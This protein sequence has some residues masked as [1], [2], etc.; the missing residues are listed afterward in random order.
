MRTPRRHG[1]VKR[2]SGI[3]WPLAV[4]F[5]LPAAAAIFAVYLVPFIGT[6]RLSFTEWPGI[7]DPK[8][9]GLANYRDLLTD[10]SFYGSVRI[11]ILFAVVVTIGVMVLATVTA[12]AVRQGRLAGMLRVIWFLP[13]IA[14]GTAIAVFW[15]FAFQ[16]ISGAVN[17]LL[18]LVGLGSSHA[19]LAS[20]SQARWAVMA[21][22]IWAGVA[23]P[24]LILVGAIGRI[25]ADLYEAAQLDGAVGWRQAWYVTIPMIQPVLVMLTLLQL[26]WS[27]NSFTIIWALTRGG[28]VESTSVLPVRLYTEAFRDFSFGA[29]STIGVLSS[30]VLVVAGLVGLRFVNSRSDVT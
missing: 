17:G 13:A 12:M 20:P 21:V 26:I 30:V 18:G 29:A 28:P 3:G 2:T 1:R 19:W 14:P 24:F 5:S 23:F 9:V 6:I 11:T 22:A 15:S 8:P 10:P 4:A 25:S 16:P 7:G 27:F